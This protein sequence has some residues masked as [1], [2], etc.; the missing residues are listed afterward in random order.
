[1]LLDIVDWKEV[2]DLLYNQVV[3]PRTDGSEL[4]ASYFL[5]IPFSNFGKAVF[6]MLIIA[7]RGHLTDI[8]KDAHF[9]ILIVSLEKK[10]WQ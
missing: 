2:L 9:L 5:K 1:M 10:R 6:R 4:G 3:G 8:M 7:T